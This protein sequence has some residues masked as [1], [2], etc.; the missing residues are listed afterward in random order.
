MMMI[1]L[2]CLRWTVSPAPGVSATR[3]A[4][5]TQLSVLRESEK[6]HY[7]VGEPPKKITFYKVQKDRIGSVPT[8]LLQLT[9]GFYI[10]CRLIASID[11]KSVKILLQDS[12][13]R[14]QNLTYIFRTQFHKKGVFFLEAP[15]YTNNYPEDQAQFHSQH[16]SLLTNHASGQQSG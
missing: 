12:H 16:L 7:L 8:Y 10:S 11:L 6:C 15:L 3:H 2:R 13:F 5:H 9:M 14:F 1:L 4:S